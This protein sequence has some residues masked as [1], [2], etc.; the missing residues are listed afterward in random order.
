M[1]IFSNRER[2]TPFFVVVPPSLLLYWNFWLMLNISSQKSGHVPGYLSPPCWVRYSCAHGKVVICAL[3]RHKMWFSKQSAIQSRCMA[4]VCWIIVFTYDNYSD[5]CS[6][7]R[8][9][10]ICPNIKCQPAWAENKQPYTEIFGHAIWPTSDS[11][12]NISIN[13]INMYSII[14]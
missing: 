5:N 8:K 10:N 9:T 1:F 3:H 14:L 12:H 2:S 13:I 6:A 7:C 4:T 11:R